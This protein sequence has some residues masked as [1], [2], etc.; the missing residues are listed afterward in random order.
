MNAYDAESS[1]IGAALLDNAWIG[2]LADVLTDADFEEP[3]H[4]TVWAA[5]VMLSNS[6]KAADLVSLGDYLG[7][8]VSMALLAQLARDTPSATNA[9]TYAEIVAD[10][11]QRRRLLESLANIEAMT[12]DRQT[13]ITMVL[14]DAQARLTKLV[15]PDAERAGPVSRDL[16]GLLDTIEKR[17]NGDMPA[18]GLGFGL[19][20]LDK[21]TMGMHA[22][23]MVIAAGR[24]GMGKTA[25]SLTVA[26]HCAVVEKRPVV[27]F[28]MEMDRTSIET[29][30]LACLGNLPIRA[31][32]DPQTH[33][34]D[35]LWA[36]MTYPVKALNEA[37]FIIDD[38]AAMTPQQIRSSAKRWRERYGDMGLVVVD[39]LQ[40]MG[41]DGRGDRNREQD[42]AEA[43]R[44]MK[45]MAKEL[46]CPVLVLSQL[47]RK[48]EERTNKRP[49]PADL[50][51]SGSLEQDA[52]MI[53]F[54][55]REE[56]YDESSNAK[57][58]AEII[59]AKQREGETG[60]VFAAANMA[61]GRF[62]DLDAGVIAAMREIQSA[63]KRK[64]KKS[65]MA[66]F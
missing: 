32:R 18:M 8:S 11:A 23:Q 35:E 26:A 36:R 22:G 64:A 57:G 6:G 56:H 24:P 66:E 25:F 16:H 14:D 20:D 7:D 41:T 43:S 65:A 19:T 63:P 62:D 15:R 60:T 52:D 10:T 21:K 48:V 44:T 45:L 17:F 30:L 9:R 38:R 42:V 40:L 1:V 28:N 13:A 59:V 27:L 53:L 3:T 5:M 33:M 39:Y 47:N 50:R 54:L 2:R 46:G 31:L 61:N 4:R 58:V 51:E 49:M 29:R 12:R 55:Y 37:P 34:N